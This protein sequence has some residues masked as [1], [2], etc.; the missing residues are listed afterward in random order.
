MKKRISFDAL[1]DKKPFLMILSLL[2]AVGAWIFVVLNISPETERNIRGVPILYNEPDAAYRFHGLH[3]AEWSLDTVDVTVRGARS[4]VQSLT[5]EDIRVM[6]VY[7]GVDAPGVYTLDL[8]AVRS[9]TQ[10]NF[11]IINVVQGSAR[12]RFDTARSA[13]FVIVAD[14]HGLEVAEGMVTGNISVY[15]S[16]LTVSG[17]EE[18]INSIARVSVVY[19]L[20][21]ELSE[22]RTSGGIEIHLWDENGRQID[23]GDISLSVETAEV[24]IPV[25]KRGLLPLEIGFLN[26]PLG[27]DISTL[28]YT[29]SPAEIEVAASEQVID[30]MTPLMVGYVDLANISLSG[31]YTF[32]VN[33]SSA[34]VNIDNM[35]V[36]T[37]VFPRENMA[38]RAVRVTDIRLRNLPANIDV[39]LL[40]TALNN[41][42]LMGPESVVEQ[43]MPT[44]VVAV[45]DAANITIDRGEMQVY[46]SFSI[47]AYDSVWVIGSYGIMVAVEPRQ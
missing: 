23:Y 7:T 22:T 12:V 8:G 6:P 3:V 28:N 32:D 41:V 18:A 11:V 21:G 36:A 16:D 45:V 34:Y 37:V 40:T 33:L 2:I 9:D 1:F 43:L 35:E 24:T 46:A 47:P 4:L 20:E 29:I 5:A 19:D 25:Y 30:N 26:A 17:S 38:S 31:A 39:E 13:R 44:S 27:F 15:P 10:Q 14:I 42:T